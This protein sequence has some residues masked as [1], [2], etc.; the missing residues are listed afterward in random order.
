MWYIFPTINFS[1]KCFPSNFSQE[2]VLKKILIGFTIFLWKGFF[3]LKNFQQQKWLSVFK[4][5]PSQT[6]N[7]IIYFFVASFILSRKPQ[8]CHVIML[9]E[10]FVYFSDWW[11]SLFLLEF[12]GKFFIWIIHWYGI[13]VVFIA[14]SKSLHYFSIKFSTVFWNLNCTVLI[15]PGLLA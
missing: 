15:I 13:W 2:I 4:E 12:R 1:S 11:K 5:T 10:N 9:A 7:M 8:F 6:W 14:L 3:F